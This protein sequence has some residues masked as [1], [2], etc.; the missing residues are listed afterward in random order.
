[1]KDNIKQ[2]PNKCHY[3]QKPLRRNNPKQ[4]VYFCCREHRKLG[5]GNKD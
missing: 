1:M 3:C 2:D 4:R 5:R